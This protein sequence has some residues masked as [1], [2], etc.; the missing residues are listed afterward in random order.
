MNRPYEQYVGDINERY[1]RYI[2]ENVNNGEMWEVMNI[3]NDIIINNIINTWFKDLDIDIKRPLIQQDCH[4]ITDR[5]NRIFEDWITWEHNVG[6]FV[7]QEI[8]SQ[9]DDLPRVKNHYKYMISTMSDEII[10]M[11]I[12][13]GASHALR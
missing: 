6:D 4:D 9:L 13:C 7:E 12:N 10:D 11:I 5:A 2:D 3:Y 8:I 1:A